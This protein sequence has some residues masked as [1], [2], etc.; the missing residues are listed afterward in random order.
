MAAGRVSAG[1]SFTRPLAYPLLG[2]SGKT[3]PPRNVE[4]DEIH[5]MS[6]Q[7]SYSVKGILNLRSP[8]VVNL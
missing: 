3:C 2:N 1:K 6:F 5:E 4:F 7:G 8:E